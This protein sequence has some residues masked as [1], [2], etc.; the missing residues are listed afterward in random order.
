MGTLAGLLPYRPEA[1]PPWVGLAGTWGLPRDRPCRTAEEVA[2]PHHP[3]H[4]PSAW[5]R[6]WA[7]AWA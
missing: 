1:G 5:A 3:H 4:L 7:L 6:A 2:P